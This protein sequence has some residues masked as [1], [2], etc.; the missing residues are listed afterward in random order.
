MVHTHTHRAVSPS[1]CMFPRVKTKTN[2]CC[3]FFQ[4][5]EV[6]T[7]NEGPRGGLEAYYAAAAAAAEAAL[8]DAYLDSG[9]EEGKQSGEDDE[10]D[11]A[12]AK[13]QLKARDG[14]KEESSSSGSSS[15]SDSVSSEI[16]SGSESSSSDKEAGRAQES[17]SPRAAAAKRL[18]RTERQKKR[19]EQNAKRD[20]KRRKRA[21]KRLRE[22]LAAQHTETVGVTLPVAG[23]NAEVALAAAESN[24]RRKLS[25]VALRRLGAFAKYAHEE[26]TGAFT[27]KDKRTMLKKTAKQNWKIA[28]Y[29][30][31]KK[32]NGDI[33]KVHERGELVGIIVYPLRSVFNFPAAFKYHHSGVEPTR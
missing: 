30:Y 17:M 9:D 33:E 8:A 1:P 12:V 15:G 11:L 10:A 5:T 14:D 27:R 26:E 2:P 28:K 13:V 22:S 18:R 21:D 23:G 31:R 32:K 29:L 6:P 20:R 16:S 19:K 7:H 4:R 3:I 25:P 24:I